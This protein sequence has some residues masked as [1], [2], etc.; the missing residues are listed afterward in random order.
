MNPNIKIKGK[1]LSYGCSDTS[2][3]VIRNGLVTDTSFADIINDIVWVSQTEWKI[4]LFGCDNDLYNKPII[5]RASATSIGLPNGDVISYLNE[6][7]ILNI[8]LI[9]QLSTA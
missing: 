4:T 9:S 7:L 5:N 3:A 6:T 2:V 1:F 8:Y